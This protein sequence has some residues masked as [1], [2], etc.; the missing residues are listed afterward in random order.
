M[1]V[2]AVPPDLPE[3]ADIS[4]IILSDTLVLQELDVDYQLLLKALSVAAKSQGQLE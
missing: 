4:H 1:P 2:R 3:Q